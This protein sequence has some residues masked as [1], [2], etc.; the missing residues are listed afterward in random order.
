MV[1]SPDKDPLGRALIDFC[2]GKPTP[3]L[4]VHSDLAEDDVY[5]VS[6]YF[7]KR[8]ELPE[9]EQTALS[10]CKGNILD[11]GAGSGC[12]S[13]LLQEQGF[14]VTA[15]DISPGAIQVMKHRGILDAELADFFTFTGR[16]FDT[17]WLMMNGIGIVGTM[18]GLH[19]FFQKAPTLLTPDGRIILDSSDLGYLLNDEEV[20]EYLLNRERAFGEVEFQMV[21]KDIEGEP[22]DW[23]YIDFDS[24]KQIAG[25]Y[26]F[27]C[28][29]LCEG[30]H[31]EYVAML[32]F[33]GT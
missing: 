28:H 2:T 16:Q 19:Q 14:P 4:T 11:I 1:L 7:R 25:K 30:P 26:S 15:I 20:L 18:A 6:Y 17:L 33:G 3:P 12:H 29:L 22:F 21:Y 10:H 27:S 32:E 8:E 9:W 23:L 5:E 24:L 13:L 31:F